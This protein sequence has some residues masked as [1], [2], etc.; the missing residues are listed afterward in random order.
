MLIITVSTTAKMGTA[1][2]KMVESSRF[3]EK[4]IMDAEINMI[5]ART[6][7]RITIINAFCVLVISVVI[8]VIRDE[9]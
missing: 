2:R 9:G 6:I 7:I 4:A 5:G 8:R 3:S 1:I